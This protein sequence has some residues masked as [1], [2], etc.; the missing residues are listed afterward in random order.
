VN[1]TPRVF[2]VAVHLRVREVDQ[3]V[4]KSLYPSSSGNTYWQVE[5]ESSLLSGLFVF[6]LPLSIHFRIILAEYS[7]PPDSLSGKYFSAT[8]STNNVSCMLMCR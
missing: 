1:W 6:L 3:L 4:P 8:I 5:T 7:N 2:Y